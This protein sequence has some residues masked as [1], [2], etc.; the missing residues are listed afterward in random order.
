MKKRL[1]PLLFLAAAPA[2]A[3]DDH[4][5]HMSHDSGQMAVQPVIATTEAVVNGI[6]AA[7]GTIRVA[8]APIAAFNWPAMTMDLQLA[9][10][11]LA[12]GLAP[13]AT[14]TLHIEKRSAVD[15]VVVWI[16]R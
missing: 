12:E 15:Y 5:H 3:A 1:I 6:D 11:D 2:V 9:E 13:G 8:H 7:G 14:V 4:A 16:D 10:P